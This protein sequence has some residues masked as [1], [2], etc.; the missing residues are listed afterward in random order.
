MKGMKPPLSRKLR[1]TKGNVNNWKY[2]KLIG[3]KPQSTKMLNYGSTELHK[4][5]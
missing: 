3:W 2:I 4:L 5:I 1:D